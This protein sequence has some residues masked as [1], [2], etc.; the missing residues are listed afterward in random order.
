MLFH[1][2]Q[3]IADEAARLDAAFQQ[4][5]TDAR[6]E[7]DFRIPAV[8]ALQE[9]AR[10]AGVRLDLRAEMAVAAG[11]ADAAF[12]RVV[13]EFERPG[14]MRQSLEHGHTAHA[15]QQLRD[16]LTGISDEQGIALSDL[17]GTATDGHWYVF[18]RSVGGVWRVDGPHARNQETTA[19]FL[20]QILA[21]GTGRA[22]T[23]R[24]LVDDF[25]AASPIAGVAIRSLY[26][27][28]GPT[29]L[30]AH[31]LQAAL[32][33]EWQRLFGAIS[34]VDAATLDR[35]ARHPLGAIARSANLEGA[36][37]S[38]L[39]F[40]VHTY[41]A[42]VSKLVAYA[43][44]GR[45]TAPIGLT[46]GEW[47]GLDD[48]TLQRRVRDLEAGG[49]FRV[50]GLRNFLEGDFFGW[51]VS[52]WD[53]DV[54]AAIRSVSGA[55]DEYDPATVEARPELTRDLLKGLYQYL[56]PRTLRHD[57][58]EYYTP[59]WLAE[60][61]LN[62][63][64]F[65]GRD[66]ERLLDPACGSGT[67]LVEAISKIKAGTTPGGERALLARIIGSVVGFDLNPL[68]VIAARANYVLA[69]GDLLAHRNTDIEIPVYLA[70]SVRPPLRAP[71]LFDEGVQRVELA[72]ETFELPAWVQSQGD[73]ER[74]TGAVE[75]AVDSR[76]VEAAF[77]ARM[78]GFAPAD[79]TE[80][81]RR[82]LLT[83]FRRM[84]ELHE[85]GRDGVWARVVKNAF[86][87]LFVGRFSH[88]VGN[89]PWIAWEHLSDPYRRS[90]APLWDLYALHPQRDEMAMPGPRA[91]S[92]MA[93]LFTYVSAD[94]YLEEDGTL[95]FL[96]TQSL[97][98]SEAAGRGF[99]RFRL[100]EGRTLEAT[101][102]HDFVA[103]QPFEAATNRT[104]LIRLRRGVT[105][106]PVPYVRWLPERLPRTPPNDLSHA[107][108]EDRAARLDWVAA[109]VMRGDL[110]S[111]W[112]TGPADVVT[113]LQQLV[114]PSAYR[115][116]T[117]EG[118]NTRGANGVYW[119][120]SLGQAPD[121]REIVTNRPDTGRRNVEQ[122]REAV[123]RGLLYPLLRGRDVGRWTARSRLLILLPYEPDSP[124]TPISPARLGA[125]YRGG[126]RFLARFEEALR[127]RRPF[128]NFDPRNNVAWELYNVGSYT[129]ARHKVVWREQA[130]G[131]GVAIAGP[132]DG[133]PVVPD[134]KLFSVGL[135]DEQEA[136]YL[137][138]LLNCTAVRTLVDSY[139]L[140]LSLS[141]HVLDYVSIPAF[142]PTN[143][144]HR[145]IAEA[146]RRAA[147]AELPGALVVAEQEIDQ[148]AGR[149]WAIPDEAMEHIREY[150]A[151]LDRG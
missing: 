38:R 8:G 41:F 15:V 47:V 83:T 100:P 96:L 90:T 57:L 29:A 35:E 17:A 86:M 112:L 70:D 75:D 68:A 28:L 106:Y 130:R 125:T 65:E 119:V 92:D 122:V 26:H 54:A 12:N 14:T 131:F 23:A 33:Q 10:R 6:T 116:L 36:Q 138:A 81:D 49:L 63:A 52:A 94:R 74:V 69:L 117:R 4:A 118:A 133:R 22:L 129:F 59:D 40:A 85:D 18:V 82:A 1:D 111:P 103:F 3:F 120:E 45:L 124:G 60:H 32:F 147:A 25:G 55:L 148:L 80:A 21:L 128:R 141:S 20:R 98:K 16:Y 79:Q 134:H 139:A 19:R 24:N 37:P 146:A 110:A 144:L 27:A 67:F 42:I 89:P 78:E 107:A 30:G 9:T 34:G 66:G 87:P 140:D 105:R 84:R 109:P 77:L 99:R 113:A 132:Q 149:L 97:F 73:V 115:A 142:A 150:R 11:R 102:V 31:S 91:R 72:V 101:E 123:E 43:A 136:L 121:G 50:L 108:F 39:L 126:A 93:A 13:I 145:A 71:G 64:G 62:C 5:A 61:A 48:L 2:R 58:G 56:M 88:V 95:V 137:A 44:V 143:A 151:S 114:G 76:L 46:L 127:D 7:E 53:G 135:D 104:S 51:Y